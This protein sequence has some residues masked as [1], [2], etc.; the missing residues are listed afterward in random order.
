MHMIVVGAPSNSMGREENETSSQVTWVLV[1]S[2]P[3]TI[4]I[5]ISSPLGLIFCQY[6]KKI[7]S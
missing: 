6:K 2:L 1:P 4:I 7:S 3:T 5:A